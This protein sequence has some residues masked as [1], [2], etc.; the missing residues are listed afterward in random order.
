MSGRE[1]YSQLSEKQRKAAV[2]EFYDYFTTT[3]G[4]PDITHE[5][6]RHLFRQFVLR[7]HGRPEENFMRFRNYTF[8]LSRKLGIL[9]AR[10][11]S[12]VR[13]YRVMPWPPELPADQQLEIYITT[14]QQ[15]QATEP[16]SSLSDGK[17]AMKA[18]IR[19]FVQ[20]PQHRFGIMQ[21]N[22]VSVCV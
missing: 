1:Y 12:G 21:L 19:I 14:L 2:K 18:A 11:S 10:T 8:L 9:K 13:T 16:I 4:S 3:D 7:A 17:E 15:L 20:T 6:L 22:H 5:S